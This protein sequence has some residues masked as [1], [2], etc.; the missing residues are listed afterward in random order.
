MTRQGILLSL[1]VG[2]QEGECKFISSCAFLETPLLETCE[3]EDVGLSD[4]VETQRAIF[5]DKT[6]EAWKQGERRE[7][8][9]QVEDND[10]FKKPKTFHELYRKGTRKLLKMGIVLAR[11]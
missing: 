4:G 11:V 3:K 2:G 1:I 5:S 7:E 9:V 8:E 10:P 6:E